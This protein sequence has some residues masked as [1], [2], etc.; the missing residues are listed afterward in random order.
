MTRIEIL[1]TGSGYEAV[2]LD[3]RPIRRSAWGFSSAEA[4]GVLL[5]TTPIPDVE[6]TVTL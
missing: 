5:L 4:L 1:K 3:E 2:L 6:I